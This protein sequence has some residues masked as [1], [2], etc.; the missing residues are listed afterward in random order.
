MG[1]KLHGIHIAERASRARFGTEALHIVDGARAVGSIA[2]CHQA[3][4]GREDLAQR[5]VGELVGVRIEIHPADHQALVFGQQQPGCHVGVMVHPRQDDLVARLERTPQAARH[6]QGE[7]GHVLT[8][9]DFVGRCPIERR[10]GGMGGIH[11]FAC[12]PGRAKKSAEIGVFLKQGF[13]G[14]VNH[15]LRHLRACGI[16]EIT[17]GFSVISEGKGRELLADGINRKGAGHGIRLHC[18]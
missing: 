17:P 6:V 5:I 1:C 8:E 11:Q 16:I 18:R 3:G 14:A 12:R 2:Q 9:H 4:A 10:D 13:H 15:P 7:R